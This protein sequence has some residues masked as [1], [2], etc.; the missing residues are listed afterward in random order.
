MGRSEFL[1]VLFAQI[2]QE[3][4]Q[5]LVGPVTLVRS[6]EGKTELFIGCS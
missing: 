1:K 5:L 3:F 6:L 2:H 4:L